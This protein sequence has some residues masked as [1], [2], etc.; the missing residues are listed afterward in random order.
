MFCRHI[1][2]SLILHRNRRLFVLYYIL[3]KLSIVS[4]IFLCTGGESYECT[5]DYFFVVLK[6]KNLMIRSSMRRLG[7]RLDYLFIVDT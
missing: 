5:Y 4:L 3:T 2:S 7:L 6:G 1:I